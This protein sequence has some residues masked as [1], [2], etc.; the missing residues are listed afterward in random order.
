MVQ[1]RVL[2]YIFSWSVHFNMQ[3]LAL[4]VTDLLEININV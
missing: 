1:F 4:S 2:E 3:E